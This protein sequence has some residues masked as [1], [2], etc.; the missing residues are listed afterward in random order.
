MIVRQGA[1]AEAEYDEPG[2]EVAVLGAGEAAAVVGED[3]V[4]VPALVD[5]TVVDVETHA[6][7]PASKTIIL[8]LLR[9]VSVGEVFVAAAVRGSTAAGGRGGWLLV[10]NVRRKHA[11][12]LRFPEECGYRIGTAVAEED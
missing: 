8:A 4:S 2:A 6:L 5:T 9:A 12:R 10:W 1:F 11:S 3:A 7:L